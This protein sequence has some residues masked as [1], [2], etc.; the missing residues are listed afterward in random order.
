MK[1]LIADD[2]KELV[3][4]LGYALKRDGYRI[5]SAYDGQTAL[6]LVQTEKP[7]LLLLDVNMPKRNGFEVLRELRRRSKVPVLMLTV[8]ADEENVINA[9]DLGAD[10]YVTKPF[11]PGE[12]RARVNALLRRHQDWTGSKMTHADKLVFGSA[13]LDPLLHQVVIRGNQV[14]LTPTEFSLLHF[15][16]LNHDGV[17]SPSAIMAHVWGYDADESDDVVRV[18]VMR[19]RHKIEEDPSHPMMIVNVPGVGY[20]FQTDASL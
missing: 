11:R 19:L 13:S 17:L 8:H 9:L 10:D 3:E 5:V 14:R 20:K 6:Q 18:F 16:M 12:L 4:L 7:D 2:D 1:V 15:L